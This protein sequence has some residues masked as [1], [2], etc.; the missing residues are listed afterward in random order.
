M[1]QGKYGNKTPD[2]EGEQ[3]TL[4]NV[5]YASCSLMMDITTKEWDDITSPGLMFYQTSSQEVLYME[6]ITYKF[7]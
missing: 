5:E 6:P 4:V 2:R 1:K 7:Q 3:K